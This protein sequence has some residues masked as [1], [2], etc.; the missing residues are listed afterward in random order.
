MTLLNDFVLPL[1]LAL[2]PLIGYWALA[3]VP[4]EE[5][6]AKKWI[7]GAHALVALLLFLALPW[8]QAALLCGALF[9]GWIPALLAFTWLATGPLALP[10]SIYLVGLGVLTGSRWR[11]D[12][13][14][15]RLLAL[16]S[17]AL[18]LFLLG[19]RTLV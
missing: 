8:W 15:E 10:M 6:V 9:I 5:P 1:V 13:H 16:G 11:V 19:A 7:L 3:R 12:T 14:S 2:T 4:D 18:T 17:I